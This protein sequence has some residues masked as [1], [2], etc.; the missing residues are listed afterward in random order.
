MR[1]LA[2]ALVPIIS[3]VS[4]MAQCPPHDQCY[5][6]CSP[7]VINFGNGGYRL[8]GADLP[9]TF[10][11]AGNGHPVSI[12]WTAAG[13]DEAFLCLDRDH[14]GKIDSGAELFGN[15]MLMQDGTPA[16]NGFVVLAQFDDNRDGM[17]DERDAILGRLLL[18]RDV[19]HDGISQPY[20]LT[21]VVGS[22]LA[23]ISLDFHWTG[24]RD[25][26]GNDFRYESQVLIRD[27]M[28]QARRHP[29]YDIFFRRVP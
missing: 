18:W 1:S 16:P 5:E 15:A 12:G 14:N 17:I 23:A 28:N 27:A 8:T 25:A 19:N 22:A 29:V 7:I 21:P 10:D 6:Y 20:E 2:Y 24:R 4:A 11:I 3:V 26:S 9:V 13:A